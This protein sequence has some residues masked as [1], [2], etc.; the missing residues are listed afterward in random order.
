MKLSNVTLRDYSQL[1]R[2]WTM[3]V[4]LHDTVIFKVHNTGRGG[5]DVFRIINHKLLEQLLDEVEN[6]ISISD[7][8][9]WTEEMEKIL[10]ELKEGDSLS[11]SKHIQG[12][13]W[14]ERMMN[15]LEENRKKYN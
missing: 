12:V 11:Q 8:R 15:L 9:W 13:D 2:Y 1:D 3:D 10:Y 6:H 14:T 7:R 5:C 4:C